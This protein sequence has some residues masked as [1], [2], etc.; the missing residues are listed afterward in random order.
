MT[1]SYLVEE[2]D[3]TIST[4]G[5]MELANKFG[6]QFQFR[7]SDTLK[8]AM[9]EHQ[10]HPLEKG[11]AFYKKNMMLR[12]YMGALR[13]QMVKSGIHESMVD[14]RDLNR[15][16]KESNWD[17]E[18]ASIHALEHALSPNTFTIKGNVRFVITQRDQKWV[19]KF[20]LKFTLDDTL[21]SVI[22]EG[23][24]NPMSRYDIKQRIILRAYKIEL[25]KRVTEAGVQGV[26][27]RDRELFTS[28]KVCDWDLD[29]AFQFLM[30]TVY[31]GPF[32][33]WKEMIVKEKELKALAVKEAHFKAIIHSKL[34]S[35]K[36]SGLEEQL[37]SV[38]FEIGLKKDRLLHLKNVLSS[39]VDELRIRLMKKGVS[40]SRYDAMVQLRSCRCSRDAFWDLDTAYENLLERS[41]K[42]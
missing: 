34:E 14:D 13:D 7:T 15:A 18:K 16:L 26:G 28:L 24:S 38:S 41:S 23:R 39:L 30:N 42:A 27:F 2:G 35:A 37:E 33:L 25:V 17:F 40:V 20:S 8:Q 29:G 36:F 22:Q 19:D 31:S 4:A 21:F 32:L 10:K 6:M 9:A 5:H 11:A 12:S 3:I 1:M